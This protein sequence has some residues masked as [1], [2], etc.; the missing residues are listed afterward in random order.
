MVNKHLKMS[1]HI[2]FPAWLLLLFFLG[3]G[4]SEQPFFDLNSSGNSAAPTTRLLFLLQ[5][6]ALPDSE[7]STLVLEESE[8]PDGSLY[9][10]ISQTTAD[11]NF[12]QLEIKAK[13]LVGIYDT[14]LQIVFDPSFLQPQLSD[15][16]LQL[17][18]GPESSRLRKGFEPIE[19]FPKL[20]SLLGAA[21]PSDSSRLLLS[22]S[23]LVDLGSFQ[24]YNGT[25]FSLSMRVLT[26]N[27]FRT[28][29][30]IDLSASDVFDKDGNALTIQYFG[31]ILTREI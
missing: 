13:N 25:L 16:R 31:G 11:S 24:E 15:E 27:P 26:P 3:C 30:G 28:I 17:I 9:L 7:V 8:I 2:I 1:H 5:D 20:V 18:E 21:H 23:L 10:N 4:S 22:Q 12:F 29:I 6:S 19:G 14:P